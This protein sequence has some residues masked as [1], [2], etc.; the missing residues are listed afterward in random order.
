MHD[1]GF[2]KTDALAGWIVMRGEVRRHRSR[3]TA[4]PQNEHLYSGF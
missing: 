3:L 2:V 1:A 4:G